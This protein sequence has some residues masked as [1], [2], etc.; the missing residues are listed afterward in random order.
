MMEHPRLPSIGRS[1][2]SFASGKG[3]TIDGAPLA[4]WDSIRRRWRMADMSRN[5]SLVVEPFATAQP[6]LAQE[7]TCSAGTVQFVRRLP[8]IHGSR[9]NDNAYGALQTSMNNAATVWR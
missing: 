8:S 7:F 2:V 9:A 4:R 5:S 1:D 6:G 3:H